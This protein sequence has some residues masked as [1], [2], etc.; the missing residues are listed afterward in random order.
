[1]GLLCD[2]SATALTPI[3]G[4]ECPFNLGSVLKFVAQRIYSTG[5]VKNNFVIATADPTVIAT[6]DTVLQAADGTKAV[7]SASKN[8]SAAEGGE[9]REYDNGNGS[10]LILGN[11]KVK[12]TFDM[13]AK[14]QSIYAALDSLA[15]ENIG[16]F[17]I[18]DN[19]Q[20][21]GLVDD[22]DTPTTYYPIPIESLFVGPMIPGNYSTPS[23]NK[24]SWS[25]RDEKW[26]KKIA[27]ITP[28]DFSPLTDLSN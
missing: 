13:L 28:S 15:C 10:M 26:S 1:M 21:W 8:N 12:M 24:L 7:I 9:A 4:D 11:S 23:I 6:W 19:D 5:V 17:L 18:D 25:F 16:V 14:N 20:I 27:R 22:V 3:S 2:C